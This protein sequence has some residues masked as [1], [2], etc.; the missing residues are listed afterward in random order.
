VRGIWLCLSL[1]F[2]A[3]DAGA[4]KVLMTGRPVWNDISTP[5]LSA[6][7]LTIRMSNAPVHPDVCHGCGPDGS[8]LVLGKM[9][10][11]LMDAANA[12][13]KRGSHAKKQINS[14]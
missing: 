2:D 3:L 8:P 1:K 6:K 7:N 11:N 4:K 10:I 14:N 13:K 12:P 5:I 9:V